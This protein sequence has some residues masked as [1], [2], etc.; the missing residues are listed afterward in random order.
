MANNASDRARYHK[1]REPHQ[2]PR[3]LD[4]NVV[5]FEFLNSFILLDLQTKLFF[6]VQKICEVCV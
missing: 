4:A 6:L 5:C 1:R 2:K 3:V